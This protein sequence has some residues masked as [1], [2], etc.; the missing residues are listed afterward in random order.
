MTLPIVEIFDSPAEGAAMTFAGSREPV[1]IVPFPRQ[2]LVGA[3][4]IDAETVLFVGSRVTREGEKDRSTLLAIYDQRQRRTARRAVLREVKSD[5]AM[6]S[7]DR[8]TL[9]LTNFAGI[10]VVDT[11]SLSVL[12]CMQLYRTDGD[13]GAVT[14]FEA[15]D[16]RGPGH[17]WPAMDR[18][19]AAKDAGWQQ[20]LIT[21]RSILLDLDRDS[22]AQFH[23]GWHSIG[24]E[25][26]R[27][28][29]QYDVFDWRRGSAK[30]VIYRGDIEPSALDRLDPGASLFHAS[31]RLLGIFFPSDSARQAGLKRPDGTAASAADVIL[32]R[33]GRSETEPRVLQVRE[34]ADHEASLLMV[35]EDPRDGV[36]WLSFKDGCIRSLDDE[37]RLGPLIAQPDR[38]RARSHAKDFAAYV[39]SRRRDRFALPDWSRDSVAATLI[40][41][42]AAVAAGL[43]DLVDDEDRLAFS[44]KVAGKPVKE[45][46]FFAR[47]ARDA[48][49]VVPELRALLAAYI[50]ALGAGGE[51]VQPWQD[52]DEGVGGLGPALRALALLDPDGLDVLRAY[53]ETRDGEHEG[54]ALNVVVPAFFKRHGWRDAAAVRFGIYATLNRFWGGRHP[55]EGFAGMRKAMARL[56]TPG[57][58]VA[59]VLREAEH[60][61]GKP[62]WGYDAAANRAAFCSLLS[63]TDPFEV[64]VLDGIAGDPEG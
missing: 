47:I 62:D 31:R 57:E 35:Y 3:F 42:R 10:T 45:T 63:P 32:W 17:S 26:R 14:S 56:L 8:Q 27:Y 41:Q 12:R 22:I 39:R 59:A 50:D 19:E 54:Y 61:G 6:V 16:G 7:V 58:A 52:P 20:I 33:I 4:S 51:G 44:Y 18:C 15:L 1:M 64:A 38:P 9:Y 2:T 25:P 24:P 34:D 30:S 36:L 43:D 23:L 37:G 49:P 5:A 46:T 21:P 11:G 60:F 13:G 48:L 28:W 53:L 40:A 55:A 29:Q